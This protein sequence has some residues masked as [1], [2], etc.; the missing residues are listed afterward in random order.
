M[1]GAAGG[2]L[3][4]GVGASGSRGRVGMRPSGMNVSRLFDDGLE[5]EDDELMMVGPATLG[6]ANHN[7]L[8]ASGAAGGAGS[9]QGRGT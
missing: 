8:F 5:A 2:G 4:S 3:R 7:P 9:R 6:G 1:G